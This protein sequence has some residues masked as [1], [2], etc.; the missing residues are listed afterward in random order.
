MHCPHVLW[1][2]ALVLVVAC[3]ICPAGSAKTDA[4]VAAA[5][6]DRPR[7]KKLQEY[8]TRLLNVVKASYGE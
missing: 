2:I 4:A 5:L 8:R 3:H 6:E 1:S 7:H